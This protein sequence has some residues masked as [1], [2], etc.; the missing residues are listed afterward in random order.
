M[1][2]QIKAANKKLEFR[3]ELN[4]A[5]EELTNETGCDYQKIQKLYTFEE[6][7]HIFSEQMVILKAKN[8]EL[9]SNEKS[10]KSEIERLKAKM[11][12]M[13]EQ[14][15]AFFVANCTQKDEQKNDLKFDPLIWHSKGR[16]NDSFSLKNDYF[17][18]FK[19]LI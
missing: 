10:L 1:R 16:N 5:F 11:R 12:K 9:K 18:R 6:Q 17:S 7:S 8:N 15:S 13:K 3:K 14:K 4:D 19:E 2:E